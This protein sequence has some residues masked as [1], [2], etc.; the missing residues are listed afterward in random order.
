MTQDQE[1]TALND[2]KKSGD[3]TE[4]D[5]KRLNRFG[6]CVR[7]NQGTVDVEVQNSSG[8]KVRL[9]NCYVIQT[10]HSVQVGDPGMVQKLTNAQYIFSAVRKG[11][12]V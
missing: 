6:V 2:A 7:V 5:T 10:N 1:I 12:H 3:K 9:N 8:R 4:R 11:K